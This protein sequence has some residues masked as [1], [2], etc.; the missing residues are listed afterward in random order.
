MWLFG[1]SYSVLVHACSYSRGLDGTEFV[2]GS[3]PHPLTSQLLLY[4]FDPHDR[5]HRAEQLE[6]DGLYERNHTG[7]Y[8]FNSPTKVLHVLTCCSSQKETLNPY[9]FMC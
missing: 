9:R 1:V 7:M 3:T 5:N 6:G 8:E 2:P 4:R